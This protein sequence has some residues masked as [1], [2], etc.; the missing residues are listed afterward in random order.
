MADGTSR[1]VRDSTIAAMG[2]VVGAV[3]DP[4]LRCPLRDLDMVRSVEFAEG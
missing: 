4:E 2:G 1:L 3:L